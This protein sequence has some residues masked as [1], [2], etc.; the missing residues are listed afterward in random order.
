[1]FLGDEIKLIGVTFSIS[2]AVFNI[3]LLFY[4]GLTFPVFFIKITVC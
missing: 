3:Y 1:M 4:F 2:Y